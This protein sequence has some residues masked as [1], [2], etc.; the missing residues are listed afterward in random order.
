MLQHQNVI[1]QKH[2]FI[3]IIHNSGLPVSLILNV[4]ISLSTLLSPLAS[5]YW[6]L[7]GLSVL[8]SLVLVFQTLVVSLVFSVLLILVST[9]LWTAS[10]LVTHFCTSPTTNLT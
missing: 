8:V 3:F 6:P 9:V 1:Q 7:H 5:P 4:G 10:F 2:L